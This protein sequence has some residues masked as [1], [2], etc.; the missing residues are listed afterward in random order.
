VFD[1]RQLEINKTHL[2]TG[3]ILTKFFEFN[4]IKEAIEFLESNI[5]PKKKVSALVTFVF[6]GTDTRGPAKKVE[7][8][9]DAVVTTLKDIEQIFTKLVN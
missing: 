3:G 2:E 8:K 9:R 1:P 4:T 7:G 5:K 6:K